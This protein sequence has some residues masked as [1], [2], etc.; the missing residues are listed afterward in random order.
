M[1]SP[2]ISVIV[3]AAVQMRLSA[4]ALAALTPAMTARAAVQALLDARL[5]ADALS[6]LARLL[7]H[8]YVVAWVCQCAQR[9]IL[10]AR[11]RA[12]LELAEAWLR[13]PDAS[14]QAAALAFAHAHRF[15]TLGAWL[16]ACAG[17]SSGN[18]NPRADRPTPVPA[19]L[20][21]IAASTALSYLAARVPNQWDLRRRGFI[22]EAIGL[23]DGAHT[24]G[25]RTHDG[26]HGD[27]Q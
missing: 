5:T 10:E 3:D 6:L 27:T 22:L 11:D 25:A 26:I 4:Q 12:G 24:S 14:R 1:S 23:L 8:R 2:T 18:L 15:Q 17:W 19:H 21:A 7:P 16:A 20:G 13:E 9:E